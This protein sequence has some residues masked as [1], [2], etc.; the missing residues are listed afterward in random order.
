MPDNSK[1]SHLT[2][3]VCTGPRLYAW[4]E[5]WEEDD[6]GFCCVDYVL[7][8]HTRLVALDA[9]TG[10]RLQ[11]YP[12]DSRDYEKS[13]TLQGPRLLVSFH[14]SWDRQTRVT[15]DPAS[16]EI[17]ERETVLEN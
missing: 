9:A 15:L 6:A 14:P 11:E 8:K 2:G 17:L 4:E 3:Q 16:G 1:R 7:E 12:F 10:T 13:L 5:Y